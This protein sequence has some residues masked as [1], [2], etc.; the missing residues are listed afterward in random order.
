MASLDD[1]KAFSERLT[2]AL[3]RSGKDV[4]S[5]TQ[6]AMQFNLRH[7]NE[8]ITAQAA[9]KWLRGKARPTSDKIET[10]AQWL[11]VSVEWLRFGVAGAYTLD[12]DQ[13]AQ[14]PQVHEKTQSLQVTSDE[15]VFL[16]EYRKLNPHQKRLLT[17]LVQELT[18]EQKVWQK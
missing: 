2:Q 16:Y 6:L 15:I 3:K 1:K 4:S 17:D 5:A 12:T 18:F 9:Q 10:L 8:P 11:N 14:Q 13:P 7:R